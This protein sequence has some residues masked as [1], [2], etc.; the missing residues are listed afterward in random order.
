MPA[1]IPAS[2]PAEHHEFG[3]FVQFATY[4]DMFESKTRRKKSALNEKNE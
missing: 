3:M 4:P 1:K 2:G